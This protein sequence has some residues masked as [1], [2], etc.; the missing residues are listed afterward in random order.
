MSDDAA[1]GPA[2][3]TALKVL[4]IEDDTLTRVTLCRI[5][6]KMNY[7][8]VEACNGFMG[9][10]MFRQEK[11]DIV[12]TDILMPDKEGLETIMEL[13]AADSLVPIIA[14]SG[15]GSM[16]NMSFLQ[17]AAKVGATRTLAKPFT[18]NDILEMLLSFKDM[19]STVQ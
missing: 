17:M 6:K 15:G 12:I 2:P 18:P 5:F 11:P 10:K 9:L 7:E 3:G 19:R 4:V 8:T 1:T 14:M 13:R 16:K